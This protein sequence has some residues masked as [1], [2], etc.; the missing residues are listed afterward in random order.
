MNTTKRASGLLIAC[1][2]L[3]LGWSGDVHAQGYTVTTSPRG[4][5][6][7]TGQAGTTTLWAAGAGAPFDDVAMT[8]TIPFAFTFYGQSYTSVQ[9]NVR[10]RNDTETAVQEADLHRRF[11]MGAWHRIFASQGLVLRHATKH[12][13]LYGVAFMKS[14]YD[15]ELYQD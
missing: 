1:A 4:M 14:V 2:A 10:A 13:F 6:R 11:Y 8:V 9:V 7:I 12:A 5:T 3:L 15:R